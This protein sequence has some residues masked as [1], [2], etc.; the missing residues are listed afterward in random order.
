MTKSSSIVPYQRKR[1][2]ALQEKLEKII[3]DRLRQ[4]QQ[5]SVKSL[6]AE[7]GVERITV[8]RHKEIMDL[9]RTYRSG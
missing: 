9:I 5:I 4:G 3:S 7:A 6:A 8:Y 2:L 1:Y